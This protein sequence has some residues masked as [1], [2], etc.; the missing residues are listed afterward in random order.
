MSPMTAGIVLS[1]V[2]LFVQGTR[3]LVRQGAP[4]FVR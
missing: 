1:T 4:P 3:C 2:L